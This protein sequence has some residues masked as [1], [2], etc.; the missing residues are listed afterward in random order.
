MWSKF[1]NLPITA[2]CLRTFL[3]NLSSP[4]LTASSSPRLFLSQ[5]SSQKKVVI[6]E[7][8]FVLKR[9]VSITKPPLSFQCTI[10]ILNRLSKSSGWYAGRPFSIKSVLNPKS[11]IERLSTKRSIIRTSFSGSMDWSRETG[12]R[13][14]C[15]LLC[16]CMNFM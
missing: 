6:T 2:V 4:V 5:T 1:L 11:L 10:R 9:S 12:K 3:S 8:I 7:L 15:V 13:L 14:I 16:P